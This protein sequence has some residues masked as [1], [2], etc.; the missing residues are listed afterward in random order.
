M[1]NNMLKKALGLLALT[2]LAAIICATAK[3]SAAT[4]QKTESIVLAGGC[5][6]GIEA[7]FQHTKGVTDAVSGYTGGSADTA[8]YEMVSGDDTDHAESVKVTYD[9]KQI[10]LEQLLTIFFTVAHNPTQLNYQGPDRG[11][12]YR[13]A[14]FYSNAEQKKSVQSAIATLDTKKEFV[15]TLEP[16]TQFYAAE[17]YHQNYA[18]E[19]SY[20]PY[21]VMYDAPKVAKLEKTFPELFVK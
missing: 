8:H 12:Q 9:P 20:Q 13:S 6:W 4:P 5:F 7:V 16:L 3:A 17:N 15:T 18:A 19:N 14:V 2:A 11:T 10:S 1:K 21:I